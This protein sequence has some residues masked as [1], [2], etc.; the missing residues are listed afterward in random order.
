MAAL[1]ERVLKMAL[2]ALLA[3]LEMREQQ[4]RLATQERLAQHLV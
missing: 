1:V 3:L 4:V 2:L